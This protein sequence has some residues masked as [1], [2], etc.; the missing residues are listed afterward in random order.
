MFS[1]RDFR[2]SSS[3]YSET[4]IYWN[5]LAARLA[6]IIVFEHL[7]FFIIYLIEWLI[8]DVPEKIQNKIDHEHFIDQRERWA[9]RTNKEN[10]QDAI[11]ASEAVSK[12]INIPNN[13]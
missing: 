9:S 10:F 13:D 5:V 1:Y 2:E 7:I 6:F 8:A 12:M 3:P 4:I 11:I